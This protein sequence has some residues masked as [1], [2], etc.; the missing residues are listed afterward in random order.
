MCCLRNLN[1]RGGKMADLLK[2]LGD[3]QAGGGLLAGVVYIAVEMR[4]T[5]RDVDHAHRR[6]DKI[7]AP[8]VSK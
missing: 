7:N 5:R 1:L 6:L 2:V 8:E 3:I 4:Y